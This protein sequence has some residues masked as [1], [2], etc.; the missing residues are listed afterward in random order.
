MFNVNEAYYHLPPE[1]MALITPLHVAAGLVNR[2]AIDSVRSQ[3]RG[4]VLTKGHFLKVQ[5]G[6]M[7]VTLILP[8]AYFYDCAD[9]VFYRQATKSCEVVMGNIEP[10]AWCGLWLPKSE[11]KPFSWLTRA[12][13]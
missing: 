12:F 8:A 5:V 3:L 4:R 2:A 7:P 1:V 13:A 6:Y 9:C 11:D 10:Y